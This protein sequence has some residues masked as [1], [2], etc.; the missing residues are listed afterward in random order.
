MLLEVKG[1]TKIIFFKIWDKR[2]EEL[3]LIDMYIL[4]LN[5]FVY[6]D[7]HVVVNPILNLG[8]MSILKN[9]INQYKTV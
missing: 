5:V 2:V 1:L 9:Y 6:M 8:Q 7:M 3:T 4:I